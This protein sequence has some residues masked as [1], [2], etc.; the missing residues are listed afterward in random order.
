MFDHGRLNLDGAAGVGVLTRVDPLAFGC[1]L[2]GAG[3]VGSGILS[4]K[5]PSLCMVFLAASCRCWGGMFIQ[6]TLHKLSNVAVNEPMVPQKKGSNLALP[7][8]ESM[9]R[10]HF[11]YNSQYN[12]YA[13]SH[14]RGS[15]NPWVTAA[16]RTVKGSA[17]AHA[18]DASTAHPGDAAGAALPPSAAA[19]GFVAHAALQ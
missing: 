19:V 10:L 12:T 8:K 7:C 13:I 16:Y 6:C 14:H 17:T 18:F 1:V 15:C 3:D 5:V 2:A 11:S 9:Q 4:S